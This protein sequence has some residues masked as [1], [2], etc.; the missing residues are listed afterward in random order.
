ME[1]LKVNYRNNAFD[2]LLY[3][4]PNPHFLFMNNVNDT[5]RF[6]KRRILLRIGIF[7]LV[8]LLIAWY[9]VLWTF[10]YWLDLQT[11]TKA[12]E[13]VLVTTFAAVGVLVTVVLPPLIIILLLLLLAVFIM[14]VQ[15]CTRDVYIIMNLRDESMI[16]N[17]TVGPNEHTRI[18]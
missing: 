10:M 16:A 3:V 1:S 8:V 11:E 6:A 5:I 12:Q 15:E 14:L 13:I 17:A 7:L 18:V 2:R 4:N 9:C